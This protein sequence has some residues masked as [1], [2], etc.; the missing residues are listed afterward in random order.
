MVDF[1]GRLT[2]L[3]LDRW[4][5]SVIEIRSINQLKADWII[6]VKCLQMWKGHRIIWS[7]CV[8]IAPMND[9]ALKV[10]NI[11]LEFYG[12]VTYKRLTCRVALSQGASLW[13]TWDPMVA[14]DRQ[15]PCDQ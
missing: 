12:L 6:I 15:Y 8:F 1:S 7:C 14:S 9:E 10:F 2:N 4:P 13:W 3:K 5:T 11:D